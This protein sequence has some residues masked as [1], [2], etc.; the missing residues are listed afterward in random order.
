MIGDSIVGIATGYG[1]EDGEIGVR[2]PV[3]AR[4]FSLP[5]LPDRLWG[6]PKPPIKWEL[7]FF[8]WE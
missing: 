2:V 1:L 8:L 4:I 5:Q 6:P 7:G 3:G